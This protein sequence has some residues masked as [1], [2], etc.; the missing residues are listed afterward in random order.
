MEEAFNNPDIIIRPATRADIPAIVHLLADDPLGQKRER[1][2]D[3]LPAAYYEAFEQIDGDP[4]NQLVV[5][6]AYGE[7]VGTLQLTMLP[8]LT[9]QGGTRA[10]IEA[11]RVDKRY[12]SHGVGQVLFEWAIEQARQAGCRMVQLTTNAE[13]ED[14]H[15]FYTRLG[16]VASHIGMKLDLTRPPAVAPMEG[17]ESHE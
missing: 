13:R 4:R 7:V 17:T 15:R 14:A 16:F 8:Y 5:V 11:V 6:E 10:Q 3:P 2:E 12:R 1:D 9:H